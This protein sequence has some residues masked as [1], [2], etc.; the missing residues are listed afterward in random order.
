LRF[1]PGYND[2]ANCDPQSGTIDGIAVF[3]LLYTHC[4]EYPWSVERWSSDILLK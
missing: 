3:S 1:F 2:I 4:G